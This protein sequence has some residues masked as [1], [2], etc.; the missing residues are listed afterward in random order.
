[1]QELEIDVALSALLPQVEESGGDLTTHLVME[2]G[3]SSSATAVIV[4]GTIQF[5]P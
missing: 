1:M 2:L 3:T 4:A 5:R